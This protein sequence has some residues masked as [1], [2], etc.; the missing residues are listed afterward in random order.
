MSLRAAAAVILVL[1]SHFVLDA[2]V[3]AQSTGSLQGVWRVVSRTITSTKK[4]IDR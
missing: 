1:A 2:S 3:L 4:A